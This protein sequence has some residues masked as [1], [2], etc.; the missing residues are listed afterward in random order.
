[1]EQKEELY[2]LTY[3]ESLRAISDQQAAVDALHA[4]SGIVASAA[5]I[6]TAFIGGEVL[7]RGNVGRPGQVAVGAYLLVAFLTGWIL[8]PRRKWRFHFEASRLQWNYIDGPEPLPPSLVKRDLALY[9][10][11]YSQH[12]AAIIDRL[13]WLLSASI[14]LLLVEVLALLFELWRT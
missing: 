13:A 3:R 2:D 8:W 11:R 6:A 1:M 10:E 4:R 5:A 9:L 7:Q 14:V 12:N